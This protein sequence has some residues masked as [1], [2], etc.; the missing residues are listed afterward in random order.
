MEVMNRWSLIIIAA[1]LIGIIALGFIYPHLMVSPGTLSTAHAGLTTDCFACHAPM[2]GA[3]S[4]RCISCHAVPDIG[5]RTTK[6]IPIVRTTAKAP[7]HQGLVATNC[8]ACHSEHKGAHPDRSSRPSF[9]HALLPVA[10]RENCA[11]CHAAPKTAVHRDLTGN[12]TKCHTAERW[13]PATFDHAKFFVLDRNHNADCATCHVNNDTSKYTCYGCHE[14]Q[15]ARIRS[16][17][18]REGI[19]NFENC[20]KCHRSGTEG[21]EGGREGDRKGRERD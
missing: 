16:K 20:V 2:L 7:F 14:H 10:T 9:S 11:S 12:C 18:L 5:L 17:H 1:N 6:G 21:D 8:M 3:S 15:P 13:K 19:P 4:A